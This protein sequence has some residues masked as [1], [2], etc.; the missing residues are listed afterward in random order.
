MMNL[1]EKTGKAIFTNSNGKEY[2]VIRVDFSKK[3]AILKPNKVVF[4]QAPYMVARGFQW[5]K[6][7]WDGGVYDLS[8]DYANE[9]FNDKL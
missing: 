9:V 1:S 8:L 7:S 5:D 2:E 3:V 4:E 6:D